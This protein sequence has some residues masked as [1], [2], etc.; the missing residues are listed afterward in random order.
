MNIALNQTVAWAMQVPE[1]V[2]Q[3]RNAGIASFLD[4]FYRGDRD[5]EPRRA[6]GAVAQVL[7][8]MN[9]PLVYTRARASGTGATA[10]L[11][12]VLLT[13]Y[14][15]TAQN[16]G[17][18]QAMFL[19][20]LSRPPAQAELDA[21]LTKLNPVSGTQRQQAVED[22]LWSLYNKVDFLFNY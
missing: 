16:S 21:A 13:N 15:Q 22:L 6:D 12:R 20:V 4:S 14:P 11:A 8:L 5:G 9:D 19:Q 10:S 17:L 18:V 1:P 2:N 7:N 3:P